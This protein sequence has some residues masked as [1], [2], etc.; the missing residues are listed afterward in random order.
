MTKTLTEQL[1]EGTLPEG[2]YYTKGAFDDDIYIAHFDYEIEEDK[3]LPVEEV[4]AP[5]PSYDEYKQLVSKT[6]QLEKKLEIATK[7]LE[8]LE[9]K[10]DKFDYSWSITEQLDFIKARCQEVLYQIKEMEGVK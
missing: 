3:R 8:E 9:S 7:A 1:R 4:L 6:R 2:Y 5:V 10:S